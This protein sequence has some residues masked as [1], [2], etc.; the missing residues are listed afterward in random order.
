MSVRAVSKPSS[1]SLLRKTHLLHDKNKA[2]Q[3]NLTLSQNNANECSGTARHVTRT[4]PVSP[5]AAG[6]WSPERP[7][8]NPAGH[9]QE[10]GGS[11]GVTPGILENAGPE[12]VESTLLLME[13]V[14]CT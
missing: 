8:S 9:S 2:N 11:T 4:I 6:L 12:W 13:R 14:L 5:R 7:H 1:S 10:L 3:K